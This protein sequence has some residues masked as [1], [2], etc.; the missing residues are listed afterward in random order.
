MQLCKQDFWLFNVSI[1]P[2]HG[3]VSHPAAHS[4]DAQKVVEGKRKRIDGAHIALQL[5]RT[6]CIVWTNSAYEVWLVGSYDGWSTQ[7]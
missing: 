6:A 7:V 4:S 1:I 2:V 5:L 3:H